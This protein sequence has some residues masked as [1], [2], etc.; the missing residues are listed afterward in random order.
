MLVINRSISS[1]LCPDPTSIFR[2]YVM[3]Q[4]DIYKT[5][6][7]VDYFLEAATWENIEEKVRRRK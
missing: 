6:M 2:L 3:D 4:I 7:Q 5:L 1:L